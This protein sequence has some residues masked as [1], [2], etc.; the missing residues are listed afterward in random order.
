MA[1]YIKSSIRSSTAQSLLEDMERNTNQYFF[2]I[3]RS[4]PWDNDQS[5]DQYSDTVKNE[6][7]LSRNI[8]GYKKIRAENILF[9][10][11]RYDWIG[12]TI[13]DQYT[14]SEELFDLDSPKIFYVYTIAR[15]IYKFLK[16]S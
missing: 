3:G 1:T 5:P 14:D 16:Q 9:A 6:Y 13:Y 8:I 11:R 15:H 10:I 4:I 2:F 7:D 12:G